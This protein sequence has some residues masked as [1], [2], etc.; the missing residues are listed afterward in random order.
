MAKKGLIVLVLLAFAAGGIFAQTDFAAMAKNTVTVDLGPTIIGAGIKGLGK[1]IDDT[2]ASTSGFGIGV[3]YE[4]QLLQRVTV[5]GRFA[6]LGGGIG[7]SEEGYSYEMKLSSFSIEGHGRYYPLRGTFFLDG[8]LG[9]ANMT[10][11]LSGKVPVESGNIS[12]SVKA[13]RGF[14]KLG[15]KLGWRICFGKNGG[16]TFEPS[17]GY[18]GGLGFGDTIGKKLSKAIGEDVTDFDD[19]FN[20]I[21]NIIFVGGPRV[22]LALGYRF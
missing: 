13:S 15:A 4:R 3:Q 11:N 1:M 16:V 20:I 17:L 21:Q 22:S 18:Y 14:F 2:G 7:I 6:Y 12:A 5:A 19:A 10:L 9:F 8:M